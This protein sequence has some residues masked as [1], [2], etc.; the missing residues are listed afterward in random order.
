MK[1]GAK[2]MKKETKK[3][4]S[5]ILCFATA[6]TMSV[7]LSGCG[8]KN[9]AGSDNTL[10]WYMFGDQPGDLASVLEKAN[11][12]IEPEIGM[13]LD[14][15]Y[16]DSASYGEKMKLKMASGEAYDLAFVGYNNPYQTAVSMGGLYDITDLIKETGIDKIMPQFY[17]DSV[18]VDGKIYGLPNIQVVSNPVSLL[19]DKSLAEE[20]NVDTQA[21]EDAACNSKNVDDLKKYAAL[22]DDLFEKVHAAKPDLYVMNPTYDLLD[23]PIYENLMNGVRIKKDGSSAQLVLDYETPEW[24]YRKQKVHE[25]Y[26]KGYIRQ[27]IASKGTA[28]SGNDE[29]RQIAVRSSTWKP[30]VET[31]DAETYGTEQV[32]MRLNK[33]Y[34]GRTAAL[35]TA[36][37]VGANSKHPKE[38]VEFLK[39][40]NTNKELFNII[41]WG[42]EG[43]HYTKNEEGLVTQIENSG[44]TD[45]GKSAWKFGDQFNAYLMVGQDAD[46]WTETE[47]MNNEAVK[48]P[49]LGFVPNTDPI[50]NELSNMQNVESEFRAKS[51]YGTVDISEWKD[52]YVQKMEQAGA[53]KVLKELQKQ[54]DEFLSSKK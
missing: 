33:P 15:K 49:M 30:G 16:I 26:Q 46:T 43:K 32:Y 4:I 45:V 54:Y 5:S 21:I 53:K 1:K 27:D 37:G 11:E 38:A 42:I 29:A 24:E 23:Q 44:Y 48:S 35:A 40:I 47:K 28:V 51:D 41:S 6:A 9:Q 14:M 50:T 2:K 8:E 17:L 52:E 39:L 7:G 3:I 25:W 18:T 31:Y 10:V 12:I 13:K 34:V 19:M 36:T 20:L 22:L